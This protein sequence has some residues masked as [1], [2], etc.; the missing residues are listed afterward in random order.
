MADPILSPDEVNALLKG[1]ADGAIPAGAGAGG[2]R[3]GV[4]AFDLTSQERSLRG[5][6][7]GLELVSARFTRQ[8]RNALAGFFG[9][10]PTVTLRA[11]ELVKFGSV[12]EH[13]PQPVSLQLFRLAPLRG[14]G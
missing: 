8:L 3:G 10:L 12:L 6:F 9:Q 11:L 5:R 14:H 4:R 1:V 7:P 2:P 13:L